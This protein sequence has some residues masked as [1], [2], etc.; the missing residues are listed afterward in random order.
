MKFY[1]KNFFTPVRDEIEKDKSKKQIIQIEQPRNCTGRKK[2][3]LF[4][5]CEMPNI[6]I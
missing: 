1:T 5:Q 6:I 3:M 4:L 2:F